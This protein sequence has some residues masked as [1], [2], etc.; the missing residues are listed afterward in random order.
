M[1]ADENLAALDNFLNLWVEKIHRPPARTGLKEYGDERAA[2][3]RKAALEDGAAA[4]K[5]L[6]DDYMNGVHGETGDWWPWPMR[7]LPDKIQQLPASPAPEKSTPI[8]P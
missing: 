5:Q 4:V 1:T 7:D 6:Y 2:E 8:T 3:A